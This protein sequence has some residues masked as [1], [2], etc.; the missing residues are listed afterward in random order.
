METS[1]QLDDTN[2]I[3]AITFGLGN[4][5]EASKVEKDNLLEEKVIYCAPLGIFYKLVSLG[6]FRNY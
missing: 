6:V 5:P 4:K 3:Y 1:V 2:A